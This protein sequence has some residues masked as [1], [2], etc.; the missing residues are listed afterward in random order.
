MKHIKRI[1]S[2]SMV[3]SL[4]LTIVAGLQGCDAPQDMTQM[5]PQQQQDGMETLQGDLQ[6][7]N[8]FLVIEQ[9]AT[10]PDRYQLAEKHP[11]DGDTRAVLKK[12]DGSEVIMSNAELT[13]L[14]EAEAAKVEA[15]TSALTQEPTA[16][17]SGGLG[18]GEMIL[19]SAAGALIGG[20]LANKLSGNA[21]YQRNQQ[22][23]TRPSA[24]ISK[25]G[26]NRAAPSSTQKAKPKSGFF[27][28][29]KSG[30]S[31]SSPK[32]FGG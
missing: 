27:G 14:A 10:D 1:S 31:N 23:N 8:F 30:S 11:T 2:Y 5:P 16:E 19:A 28:G 17:S 26:T 4:G 7:Q 3:G 32:S 21:N 9:T 22:A 6:E 25:P 18:L 20:M 15:G 29:N 24:R 12:L 13:A